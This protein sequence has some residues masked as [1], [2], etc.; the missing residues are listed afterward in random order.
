MKDKHPYSVL[1]NIAVRE[2]VETK[3]TNNLQEYIPWS[4]AWALMKENYPEANRT[5]YESPSTGLNYFSDGRFAYV[6][7]GVTIDGIEH[8]DYLPVMNFRNASIPL[9]E[10]TSMD[11]NKTIQRSTTKAIAMHGL[12]LVLW[13][14]E[15]DPEETEPV[16]PVETEGNKLNKKHKDWAVVMKFAEENKQ[17][18]VDTIMGRLEAR[19][20]MS[21]AVVKTVTKIVT[22]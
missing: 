13:T 5:V 3:G 6:K 19:Y 2:H 8:I 11:V 7:V 15:D 9:G 16:Q 14:G 10:L 22:S 12:G 18:G 20:T 4:K 1:S 17:L 21:D